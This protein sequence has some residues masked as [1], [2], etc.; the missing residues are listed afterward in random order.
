MI[1]I[2]RRL[3]YEQADSYRQLFKRI[4]EGPLPLMFHCSAGKDR[5]GVAAALLLTILGV[6]RDTIIED[7]LLTERFFESCCR[8]VFR[9][10]TAD[11][12]REVDSGVWEPMLRAE[13]SYI[14]TMFETLI[15]EHGSVEAYLH[16]VV[17]ADDTSRAAIR[18]KL[19]E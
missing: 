4:A 2:Y 9:D 14:E 17:G 6:P 15:A 10:P 13:R 3:P 11:R 7:Y 1:E 12:F 8:M 16:D 19:V 18:R 5:T